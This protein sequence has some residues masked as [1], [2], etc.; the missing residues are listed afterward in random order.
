[1]CASASSGGV[2][3]RAGENFVKKS[4]K[5]FLKQAFEVANMPEAVVLFAVIAAICSQ[6]TLHLAME[7]DPY[8]PKE[9]P[10]LRTLIQ[11]KVNEIVDRMQFD[12][13]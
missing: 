4:D 10:E 3:Q 6:I 13:K 8:V 2:S 5:S 11:D 7:Y 9:N 12:M 1:M